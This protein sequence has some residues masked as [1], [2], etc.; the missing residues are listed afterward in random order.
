MTSK[1]IHNYLTGAEWLKQ[2][3]DIIS[4]GH[5]Y[6]FMLKLQQINSGAEY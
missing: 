6:R 2:E 4:R 5:Y 3:H 1:F